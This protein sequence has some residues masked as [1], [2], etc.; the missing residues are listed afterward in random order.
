MVPS[1]VVIETFDM[2]M[3]STMSSSICKLSDKDERLGKK[4]PETT[5]RDSHG[6]THTKVT[7]IEAKIF[8]FRKSRNHVS[9]ELLDLAMF[10]IGVESQVS[11]YWQ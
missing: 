10:Q 6:E 5:K 7:L 8:S 11:L 3:L 2:I 4:G 1:R 9:Q